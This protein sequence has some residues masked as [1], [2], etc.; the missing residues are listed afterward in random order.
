MVVGLLGLRGQQAPLE[1]VYQEGL[2][3]M[4]GTD[5]RFQDQRAQQVPLALQ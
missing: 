5:S 2:A 4:D 1:W 3:R